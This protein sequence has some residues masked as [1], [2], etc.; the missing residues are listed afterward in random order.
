[1]IAAW[2]RLPK[3]VALWLGPKLVRSLG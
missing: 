1:V 2:K 3:P